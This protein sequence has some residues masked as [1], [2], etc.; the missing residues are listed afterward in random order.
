MFGSLYLSKKP[1]D[2]VFKEFYFPEIAGFPIGR[3]DSPK[4]LILEIHYDNPTNTPGTLLKTYINLFYLMAFRLK[5]DVSQHG[6]VMV[7]GLSGVH[8]GL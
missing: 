8:F 1:V 7:R 5:G 6:S 3:A 2:L 4:V